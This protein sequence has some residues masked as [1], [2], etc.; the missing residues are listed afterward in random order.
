MCNTIVITYS[1]I[2]DEEN[3]FVNYYYMN[4]NDDPNLDD[5]F[6]NLYPSVYKFYLDNICLLHGKCMNDFFNIVIDI[7]K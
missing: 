2:G 6:D 4:D 1:F 3:E 7:L 5:N